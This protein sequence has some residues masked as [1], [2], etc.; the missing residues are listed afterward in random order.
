MTVTPSGILSVPIAKLAVLV[1]AT[2][3]FQT[4]T[5]T[6]STAEALAFTHWPTADDS[7]IARPRALVTPTND[8]VIRKNGEGYWDGSCGLLLSFEFPVADPDADDADQLAEFTN[9]VGE[10]LNQMMALAGTGDSG[11]GET[12]I[13][14]REIA[15]DVEPQRGNAQRENG[16]NVM[17]AVFRVRIEGV[18]AGASS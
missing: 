17:F 13:N 11:D 7:V 18:G 10:I 14:V 6:V 4:A 5:M 1:A 15:A 3:R 2:A 12:H 8:F 16:A 9:A